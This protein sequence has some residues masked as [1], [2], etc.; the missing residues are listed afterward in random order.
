MWQYLLWFEP[1]NNFEPPCL[2]ISL[3]WLFDIFVFLGW[4]S[5]TPRWYFLSEQGHFI[6]HTVH[7]KIISTHPL[8]KTK[9]L[10]YLE[11]ELFDSMNSYRWADRRAA[12][13]AIIWTAITLRWNIPILRDLRRLLGSTSKEL[14][15]ENLQPSRS[16]ERNNLH[17][18][19]QL[20]SPAISRPFSGSS[21][22]GVHSMPC[23]CF[24]SKH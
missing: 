13:L 5:K 18:T 2:F 11:M 21:Y 1:N 24:Y 19:I 16:F 23:S 12:S 7:F 4:I 8:L 22:V 20:C 14:Y 6:F 3:L 15:N 17:R 9:E 10:L